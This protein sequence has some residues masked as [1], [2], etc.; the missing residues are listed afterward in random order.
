VSATATADKPREARADRTAFRDLRLELEEFHYDYADALERGEVEQW[1]EFFTDD[2]FYCIIAR[3]NHE[4]G[5]PLGLVYCEGKGML[6]DR[7]FALRNTEM[8]AP[9]YLNLQIN[10][11][12]V[13]EAEG[14]TI[15][16]EANYLLLETLVE[17]P[18]RIQQVGKYYDVFERVDGRLLIAERK[19]VYDSVVI[20]NCLVF[21]V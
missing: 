4:S 15:R 19:C 9:R 18:S 10:N 13:H 11:V 21:P 12:R 7:A 3:D 20:N 2:A 6:K 17:E 16:A 5:L 1:C 8:Y 14:T